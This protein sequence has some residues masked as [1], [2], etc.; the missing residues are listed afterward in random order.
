MQFEGVG[1]G[2]D[3]VEGVRGGEDGAGDGFDVL[4]GEAGKC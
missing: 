3:R 4:E 1:G 2:G